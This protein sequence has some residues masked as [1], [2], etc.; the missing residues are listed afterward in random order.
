MD[1][2]FDQGY[3]P[4]CGDPGIKRERLPVVVRMNGSGALQSYCIT[5]TCVNGHQYP[6]VMAVHVNPGRDRQ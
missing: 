5:D 2:V 4:H 6:S 3:C 1:T